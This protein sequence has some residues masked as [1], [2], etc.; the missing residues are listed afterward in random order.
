MSVTDDNATDMT[1]RRF[2]QAGGVAAATLVT[3]GAS[4]TVASAN[5]SDRASELLASSTFDLEADGKLLFGNRYLVQVRTI[6]QSFAID[7]VGGHVY[8]VQIVQT[9]TQLPGDQPGDAVFAVRQARGDLCMSKLD[10]QGNLL[11]RMFLK[12]FGHGVAIGLERD[13]DQ[14]YLWT[15]IDAVTEGTSGWGTKLTR[16]EFNEGEVLD[17]EIQ[18]ELFRRELLPGVDRT[19]CNIDPVHNT[20]VMRHRRDGEFRL[21]LFDLDEV[22]QELSSYTPLAEAV[23]PAATLTDPQTGTVFQGYTSFGHSLYLLD[24]AIYSASNP[25]PPDGMGNAH[26][27]RVDWRTG[28]MVENV[29][30]VAGVEMHRREKRTFC[31]GAGGAHM[32]MEERAGKINEERAREAAETG[33]DTLAV[34][35]PFCTV[36]LDDGVRQRGD[37]MR[38]VDVATLLAESMENSDGR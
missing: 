36:M 25:P 2:L 1:R 14:V 11:G 16:F 3:G 24:G 38:V 12:R 26:L 15:E 22:K 17:A 37:D 27:T 5:P 28:E 32:W 10:I 18:P 33:A 19:T 20:L 13:G 6:M 30:N 34:A 7:S 9:G 21:A 31:C 23:Q 29:H 8:V 4:S 35:C